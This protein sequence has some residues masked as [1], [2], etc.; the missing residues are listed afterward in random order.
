M[1]EAHRSKFLEEHV[2][3]NFMDNIPFDK[4]EKQTK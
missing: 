2:S 3:A 4:L 1:I